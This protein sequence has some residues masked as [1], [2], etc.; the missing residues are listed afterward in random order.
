VNFQAD[1]SLR[2][3]EYGCG[4]GKRSQV[5]ERSNEKTHT[6]ESSEATRAATP[7]VIMIACARLEP[8][9]LGGAVMMG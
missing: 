1:V 7:E 9:P 5:K 3:L 8:V 4:W 6:R 2:V